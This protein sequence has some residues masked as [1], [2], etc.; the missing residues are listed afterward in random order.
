MELGIA[1]MALEAHVSRGRQAHGRRHLDFAQ[2]HECMPCA[3]GEYE[4]ADGATAFQA[5]GGYPL[6]R[7]WWRV[8]P[9]GACTCVRGRCRTHWYLSVVVDLLRVDEKCVRSERANC[10]V[11]ALM[12]ASPDSCTVRT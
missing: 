3:G 6:W 9:W 4:D 11:R 5:R 10:E 8:S 1:E 12:A 7:I 2:G